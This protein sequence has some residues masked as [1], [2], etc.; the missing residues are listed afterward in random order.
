M[1]NLSRILVF[2]HAAAEHPGIFCNYFQEDGIE[3]CPVMLDKGEQIPSLEGFDGLWVM[4][5][6][7]NVW[8]EE[9][10]P[11][12]IQEKAVI[13]EAVLERKMP[14]LGFCL[15]HQLLSDALGGEVG[16]A[17]ESEIGVFDIHKTS[18]GL[19][20]SFLNSLPDTLKCLQWHSAEVKQVPENAKVLA[21]SKACEIQAISIGSHAYSIQFHIEA[22]QATI[23][24]WCEMPE[25][26]LALESKFGKNAVEDMH[27]ETNKH[28]NDMNLYSKFMYKNWKQSI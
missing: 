22:T 25:L 16:K 4:G 14:Y 10:F 12:L 28:L 17:E 3:W 21:S 18:K 24:E 15:G 5:G 26:K 8:E 23:T 1:K 6:P 9:Q 20:S 2:Q 7:M 11:W 27:N 13:R 19:D